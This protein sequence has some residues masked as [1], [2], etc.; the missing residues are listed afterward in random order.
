MTHPTP[1]LDLALLLDPNPFDYGGHS[2]PEPRSHTS[3]PRLKLLGVKVPVPSE[4]LAP[5]HM[6]NR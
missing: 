4:R 5:A 3:P 2:V 1:N 6:W